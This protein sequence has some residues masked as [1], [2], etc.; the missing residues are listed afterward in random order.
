MSVPAAKRVLLVDDDPVNRE[1]LRV[2]LEAEGHR[3]L[4]SGD[5]E[6]ALRQAR[7]ERP[8]LILLDA[9]MPGKDGFQVVREL[10]ADEA[11]RSIPVIM[12][13]ALDDRAARLRALD[14]GAE[15]FVAK[16]VDR[17]ELWVRVRNL[18]RLK[19]CSDLL[20]QHN[21]ALERL[22]RERSAQLAASHLDTI[23]TIMRAAEFRDQETGSHIKRISYYCRELAARLGMDTVFVDTIF[24]ASPLHDVGKIGIPD[25]I[26]LKPG[27]LDAG[28]WTT[29]QTHATLGARI[30]SREEGA[31][32]Y[33]RM[34]ADIAHG[35]HERWDGTGYPQG[36]AGEAIPASARIMAICDVYDALRSRRPYKPPMGH[37]AAME[38]ILRGD[39]R[40][41]PGHFD[42]A[43][44]DGFAHAAADFDA[45]YTQHAD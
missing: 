16:P 10:K 39:G 44:L 7:A 17:A 13:T 45:I 14:C 20:E 24:H 34:G 9:M 23:Y 8:D 2:L 43:V 41:L 1:Y 32:A 40:T 11:T 3:S 4:E 29:M 42:P 37:A 12:V 6:H 30:L 31:S 33:L 19:E 18:L 21:R 25:H 27:P 15:E 38:V 22:V 28:E 5:G 36:L 35:H 26:L